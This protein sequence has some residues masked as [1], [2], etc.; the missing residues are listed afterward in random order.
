MSQAYGLE[1]SRR[2]SRPAAGLLQRLDPPAAADHRRAQA[3]RARA[4][5]PGRSRDPA[6]EIKHDL[7]VEQA[8]GEDPGGGRHLASLSGRQPASQEPGPEREQACAATRPSSACSWTPLGGTQRGEQLGLGLGGDRLRPLQHRDPVARSGRRAGGAGRPGPAAGRPAPPPRSRPAP[9]R[10][11]WR[12]RGGRTRAPPASSG[13]PRQGDEGRRTGSERRPS[14]SS[15]MARARLAARASRVSSSPQLSWPQASPVAA[16]GATAGSASTVAERFTV[17]LT[18][19]AKAY[20][21]QPLSSICI[22]QQVLA[23]EKRHEQRPASDP[24]RRHRPLP[25][26]DGHDRRRRRRR[27][28]RPDRAPLRRRV[29]RGRHDRR[30]PRD[31]SAAGRLPRRDRARR[32]SAASPAPRRPAPTAACASP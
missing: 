8:G 17:T 12:G 30:G 20:Q 16:P 3:R 24:P 2:R 21:R 31:R 26:D 10:G 13:P 11:C 22:L 23:E 14:W 29:R 15:S 18:F 9:G 4:P 32:S 28:A 5:S 25:L 1:A 6:P 7:P 27:R 19:M